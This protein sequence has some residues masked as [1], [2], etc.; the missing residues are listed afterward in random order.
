MVT[1]RVDT[2]YF[3]HPDGA[4]YARAVDDGRH[5]TMGTSYLTSPV[6]SAPTTGSQ[7]T[8]DGG[9]PRTVVGILYQKLPDLPSHLA[10]RSFAVLPRSFRSH[11]RAPRQIRRQALAAKHGQRLLHRN[12][13]LLV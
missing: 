2:P 7:N 9:V 5:V 8:F 6:L 12:Y 13:L 4:V 10:I 3:R 11:R 1:F